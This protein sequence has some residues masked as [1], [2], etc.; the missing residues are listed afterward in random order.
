LN[1]SNNSIWVV[2]VGDVIFFSLMQAC[3]LGEL[4][5][6]HVWKNFVSKESTPLLITGLEKFIDTNSNISFPL[7][8][9][10]GKIIIIVNGYCI[11]SFRFDFKLIIYNWER[12]QIINTYNIKNSNRLTIRF[13]YLI[14]DEGDGFKIR[15]FITGQLIKSFNDY[16]YTEENCMYYPLLLNP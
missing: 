13:N 8:H 15:D 5:T 2:I 4:K 10:S 7:V 14:S 16:P 12:D 1:I 6:L 11:K 9:E 3:K